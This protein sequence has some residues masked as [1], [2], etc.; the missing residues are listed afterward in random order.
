MKYL[1]ACQYRNWKN[2]VVQFVHPVPFDTQESAELAL[3]EFC[4]KHRAMGWI[5]EIVVPPFVPP[6]KR[7]L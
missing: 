7:V 1:M 4:A 5:I 3:P 6:L 2:E